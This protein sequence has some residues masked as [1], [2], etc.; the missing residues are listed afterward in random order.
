MKTGII[1]VHTH[2]FPD[3]IAKRAVDNLGN[4]YSYKMHG[5]GTFDDL[6]HSAQEAGVSKLVVHST[7]LKPEQVEVINNSTASR[8]SENVAGFGTLHRDYTGGFE[9]EVKRI[10][11]LGLR[12]IKLHPDFQKFNIDDKKMYPVY[13]II[14]S[15]K[16][17][18]LFHVGDENCDFSSPKRLSSV[19]RDFPSLI[20]IAAHLGGYSLWDEAQEYVLGKNVYIDT[21]SCFRKISYAKIR[22]LIRLHDIDK[23]MF[24]TDYPIERHKYCLDEFYK[25]EL[26]DDETE[27]ILFTNANRLIFNNGD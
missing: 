21:S 23:V 12:G 26:T 14:S 22:S 16:L 5:N 27:K 9:K 8:I 19:I 7:A 11:S 24:G 13:E 4:Y 15:E 2:F 1:D 3:A 17:P 10:K 25:L 18:V 6:L 20:I